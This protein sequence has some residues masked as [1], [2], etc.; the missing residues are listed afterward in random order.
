MARPRRIGWGMA[1]DG[2]LDLLSQME[3]RDASDLFLTEGNS[4]TIPHKWKTTN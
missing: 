4:F 3:A 1:A 2:L